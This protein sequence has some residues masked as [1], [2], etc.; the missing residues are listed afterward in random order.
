MVTQFL[1]SSA[2]LN[3][4]LP[5]LEL[6]YLQTLRAVTPPP[7]AE[8]MWA[9]AKSHCMTLWRRATSSGPF[10][11]AHAAML[12]HCWLPNKLLGPLFSRS[13]LLGINLCVWLVINFY[14][15]SAIPSCWN[16][17]LFSMVMVPKIIALKDGR[18][19]WCYKG[20]EASRK[21]R[22]LCM[23]NAWSLPLSFHPCGHFAHV[24]LNG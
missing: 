22:M 9:S 14:A 3:I 21:P 12:R 23:W 15:F 10:Y 24:H 19:P 11:P 20:L 2:P 13:K 18:S 6:T 1:E 16:R 7:P 8:G 4:Y 17:H 5:Y